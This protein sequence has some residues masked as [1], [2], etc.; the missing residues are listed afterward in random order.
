MENMG[1]YFEEEKK[2]SRWD[3]GQAILHKEAV[4]KQN[5]K[6]PQKDSE[7]YRVTNSYGTLRYLKK[8][9]KRGGSKKGFDKEGFDK[10]GFVVEAFEAPGTPVHTEKEKHLNRQNMKKI[11]QDSKQTLF[12]SE[13]PL[14]NQALFFNMT[15][16]KRSTDLLKYMKGLLHRQGHQTLKDTFGF[17]DQEPERMELEALNYEQKDSL[18]SQ[19]KQADQQLLPEERQDTTQKR[20]D[21]LNNRLLRKEAKERQLCNELQLMIDQ[22]TKKGTLN[23]HQNR[24]PKE[25]EMSRKDKKKNDDSPQ[26]RL[27]SS[28]EIP[29]TASEGESDDVSEE[30]DLQ[31]ES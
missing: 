17:L 28:S 18:S 4:K 2:E 20:I 7:A 26:R 22:R 6:N 29:E 25:Q 14:R 21:T 8:D 10:E 15:G 9:K 30:S 27:Y 24:F 19:S 23:E 13:L 16:T 12:S 5:E 3:S 1:I 11:K 31:S